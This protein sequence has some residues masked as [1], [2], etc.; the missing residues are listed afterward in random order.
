MKLTD[1][2][3]GPKILIIIIAFGMSS[4]GMTIWQ[5][6]TLSKARQQYTQFITK[7]DAAL[8]SAARMNQNIYGLQG[9]VNGLVAQNCPTPACDTFVAQAKSMQQRFQQRYNDA[10]TADPQLENL[11]RPLKDR[12][13]AIAQDDNANLIPA[14]LHNDPN[15]PAMVLKQTQPI[16]DLITDVRN[17][18]DDQQKKNTAKAESLSASIARQSMISLIAS[19]A[20]VLAVTALA[21]YVAFGDIARNL[22]R[23][24]HQMLRVSKGEL[25]FAVDGQNRRDEIGIM[26][27]TLA[28]FQDGLREAG[29]L[30]DEAEALKARSEADRRQSMLQLAD[31]FEKSVG[32]IVSMVASAATEMQAAATQLTST[33]QETSSQSTVVASA[34]EEAGTNVTSVASAAEEMGASV[35]E[36]G[37]QVTTSSAMSQAAVRQAD[38]AAVVVHELND[39]AA[40]IGGI[41]EMI[42]SLAGQ[43]NLLALNA[44]IESARAGD[45]GKGFAVVAAEVKTLAAQTAKATTEISDKIGQ[46]QASTAKA[47]NAFASITS[48]IQSMNAT[49]SAIASAVEQQSSATQ[50]I[51]QAVNQASQGTQEVTSNI[52]SVAKASEQTSD[53]AAQVQTSASELAQ[54]AE[55]LHQEMDRFLQ[56]IRAA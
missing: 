53:A 23:L 24:N 14:G 9:A 16:V 2:K 11:L 28:V 47:A 1:I 8:L 25:D 5:N 4:L 22:G 52:T 35:G 26:A 6:M 50:E 29:R 30:R 49:N 31:Q 40:S 10:I 3:I 20:I 39:V 45:A 44:T 55:R 48:S 7:N 32:G 38:E 37:R 43:T 54:Q 56:T 41:V 17:V 12:F 33:A 15:S 27:G 21:A 36:I 13:D 46:I 19:I 42:S 34:A 18:V 51:I